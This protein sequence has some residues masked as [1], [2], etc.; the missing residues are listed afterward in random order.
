ML[1]VQASTFKFPRT[2]NWIEFISELVNTKSFHVIIS[3]FIFV[4]IGNFFVILKHAIVIDTI[5]LTCG[6]VDGCNLFATEIV[7][8]VGK[9]EITQKGF[10]NDSSLVAPLT[11]QT[12]TFKISQS[13]AGII[14]KNR[15]QIMDIVGDA[16]DKFILDFF[17]FIH[18]IFKIGIVCIIIWYTSK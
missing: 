8:M 9:S 5:F 17:A 16:I 10:Q 7:I 13:E 18:R 3:E 6:K 14:L 15:P 2:N 1:L 4:E 12:A 11:N